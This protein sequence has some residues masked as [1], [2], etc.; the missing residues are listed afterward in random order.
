MKPVAREMKRPAKRKGT[1]KP[2][3]YDN[4]R[5]KE[6]AGLTAARVRIAPRIAPTHGLRPAANVAPKTKEVT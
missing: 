4:R 6:V 2:K 1:L 3:E 5:K